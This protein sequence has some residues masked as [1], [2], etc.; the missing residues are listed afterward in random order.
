MDATPYHL[1][2]VNDWKDL[3]ALLAR[4]REQAETA[5]YITHSLSRH[6]GQDWLSDYYEQGG[7]HWMA[8][9]LAA[10]VIPYR[11]EL[12]D[13][14]LAFDLLQGQEGLQALLKQIR[15]DPSSIDQAGIQIRL[16]RLELR[17]SAKV[18]LEAPPEAG[19]WRPDVILQLKGS[20]SMRVE[21]T[22]LSIGTKARDVQANKIPPFDA[23]GRITN[24]IG[25][26]VCQAS[27]DEGWIC[28]ELDD[29]S[30]GPNSWMKHNYANMSF[31]AITEH[32]YSNTRQHL[33]TLSHPPVSGIV[34]VS[35]PSYANPL[36][37]PPNG[38]SRLTISFGECEASTFNISGQRTA[39]TFIMPSTTNQ[40]N[41]VTA[42][43]ELFSGDPNWTIWALETLRALV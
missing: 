32:I 34:L 7:R 37:S 22:K 6:L 14:A 28:M 21:C 25:R 24:T 16:A 2:D 15:R 4:G 1:P 43:Q 33:K 29:G 10:D 31:G 5:D 17:R 38:Q 30:F 35:R 13:L 20:R 9:Q 11:W 19:R 27:Q 26:K 8:A 36:Y 42:W 41:Q 40:A 12:L 39:L 3:R 18:R 23:W